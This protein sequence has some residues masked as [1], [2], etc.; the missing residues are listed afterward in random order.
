M[1]HCNIYWSKIES[2]QSTN[3][4]IVLS[5]WL[6]YLHLITLHCIITSITLHYNH[7]PSHHYTKCNTLCHAPTCIIC[8]TNCILSSC[9][10]S[11]VSLE[12]HLK[13]SN[14]LLK[15]RGETTFCFQQFHIQIQIELQENTLYLITSS[16]TYCLTRLM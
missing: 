1:L 11:V 9:K 7:T 13:L 10:R 14:A 12:L 8:I 5:G 16:T 15:T 6:H 3:C 2:Y 4:Y